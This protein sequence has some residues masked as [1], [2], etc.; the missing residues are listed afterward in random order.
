MSL[1]G[2]IRQGTSVGPI[3]LRRRSVGEPWLRSLRLKEERLCSA[4]AVQLVNRVPFG[5]LLSFGARR[6]GLLFDR[7]PHAF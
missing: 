4:E 3:R 5:Q 7:R 2:I 6:D 1:A